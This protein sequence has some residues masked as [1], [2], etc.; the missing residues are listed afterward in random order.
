MNARRIVVVTGSRADYGLLS[1]L[2]REVRS[3]PAL[4][5]QVIATGAHLSP[6]FGLTVREIEADGFDVDARVDIG[7][8]SDERPALAAATGRALA[9]LASALDRIAPDVAVV[10]GDRYEMLAAASAALILDLPVAHI[11]GGEITEGAMDDSIRHAITKMAS[12]H[13]AAAEPYARRIVQM[14]E[15]PERVFA[16]GA[17]GVD[18][19]RALVPLDSA[20]LDRDLGLPL[21]DPTLLVAYHPET[22]GADGGAR[23]IAALLAAL[24]R[25]PE[26]RVVVTG[27]NADPGR[28]AIAGRLADYAARRR[29]RVTLH[30]SLGQRRYL[31]VM[32]RAAAVIGNSSSGVIEAPALGVPTVDIGARQQ[33]RL[34][35][36][37]VIGAE[38]N[39]DAIAAALARALDPAFRAGF[40]GQALPYGGGG[41][42]KK[43]AAIL[44]SADLARLR[45][46]RF[47]DLPGIAA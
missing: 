21:R 46:K 6:K 8:A 23:G 14:G 17:L 10:L 24:E 29:D 27:V 35:A 25:L 12:V 28:E 26:A 20:T 16:V 9:G 19:A 30:D 42:A 40:A 34:K 1:A 13:F 15:P 43:I 33:G 38:E 7:L 22:A 44:K 47:H 2:M 45:R 31:S 39:A 3:D 36:R 4:E 11:H 5:L 32:R 37:S 41:V 18:A